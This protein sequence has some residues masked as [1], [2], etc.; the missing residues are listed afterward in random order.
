MFRV[1]YSPGHW[2][3]LVVPMWRRRGLITVLLRLHPLRYLSLSDVEYLFVCIFPQTLTFALLRIDAEIEL[4]L[5]SRQPPAIGLL[6]S[7]QFQNNGSERDAAAGANIDI[8]LALMGERALMR[9]LVD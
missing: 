4:A 8:A 6:F 3:M 1:T 5:G 9:S 2:L 7:L